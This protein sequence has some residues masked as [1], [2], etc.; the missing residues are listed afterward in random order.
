MKS[1]NNEPESTLNKSLEPQK[2]VVVRHYL[3]KQF[4]G[5]QRS[6]GREQQALHDKKVSDYCDC[7]TWMIV[8]SHSKLKYSPTR[9]PTWRV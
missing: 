3:P 9:I 2:K 5:R 6:V 4:Y 1:E 8:A 7:S